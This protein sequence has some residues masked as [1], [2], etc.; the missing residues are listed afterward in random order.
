MTTR[1]IVI[2]GPYVGKVGLIAGEL[3]VRQKRTDITKAI[4][5]FENGAVSPIELKNLERFQQ[6]E[7]PL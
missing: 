4:V 1:V 5:H 3:E 6:Q 7:L 2:R